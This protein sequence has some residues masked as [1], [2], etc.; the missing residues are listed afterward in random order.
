MTPTEKTPDEAY[1]ALRNVAT[2]RL[3]LLLE[4]NRAI[5]ELRAESAEMRAAEI[6]RTADIEK[7]QTELA[8]SQQRNQAK[9]EQIAKLRHAYS[10]LQTQMQQQTADAESMGFEIARLHSELSRLSCIGQ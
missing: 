5:A 9:K 2:T 3:A 7:I 10:V 4:C 6:K 8:E 1:A